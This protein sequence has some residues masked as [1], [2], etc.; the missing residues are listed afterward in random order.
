MEEM[1]VM[2]GSLKALN[3]V[4]TFKD[5]NSGSSFARTVLISSSRQIAAQLDSRTAV[6]ELFGCR[7]FRKT[8]IV[9]YVRRDAIC[10]KD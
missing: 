9:N 2:A 4:G 8:V 1:K 5:R 6:L 3:D 7:A 10:V